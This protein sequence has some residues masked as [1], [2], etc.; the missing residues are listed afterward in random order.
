MFICNIDGMHIRWLIGGSSVHQPNRRS[1]TTVRLDH[2]AQQIVLQPYIH[3]VQDAE[4]RLTRLTGRI[5]KLLP[6][7][8]WRRA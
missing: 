7:C 8:R 3:A 5:E 4:V 1:L 2:P 6:S